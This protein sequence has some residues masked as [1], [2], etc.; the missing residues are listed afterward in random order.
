MKMDNQVG[1][2]LQ[3][4]YNG[5]LMNYIHSHSHL[6]QLIG[7]KIDFFRTPESS[8]RPNLPRIEIE[9]LSTFLP[10]VWALSKL[11]VLFRK[12]VRLENDLRKV[13]EFY[14]GRHSNWDLSDPDLILTHF[15]FN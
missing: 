6:P 2:L 9:G 11:G 12:L 14:E 5:W 7:D 10:L 8:K 1:V 13:I 15:F 4:P 3:M